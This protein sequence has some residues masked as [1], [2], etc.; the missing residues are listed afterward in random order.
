MHAEEDRLLT[1]VGVGPV[2][3]VGG[4]AE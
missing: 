2:Y 4:G 1:E 3:R